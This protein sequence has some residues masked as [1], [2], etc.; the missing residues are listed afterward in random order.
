M[1]SKEQQNFPFKMARDATL[2][3]AILFGLSLLA[4][5]GL[6]FELFSHFTFQYFVAGLFL[7]A[8]FLMTRKIPYAVF[9]LGLALACFTIM[10]APITDPIR[11]ELNKRDQSQLKI[12]QFNVQINHTNQDIVLK[13][14]HTHAMDHDALFFY[15]TSPPLSAALKTLS[16]IYPYQFH[17]PRD[18]AFGMV[19]L[20][21][22]TP[23]A[24]QMTPLG[25]NFI[26]SIDIQPD[27]FKT[28]VRIFSLHALPPG[29]N[30]TPLRDAELLQ[31]AQIIA[32]SRDTPV[33]FI[34]DWNITPYAPVFRDILTIT[35]LSYQVP[36]MRQQPTWPTMLPI[37]M[38]IPIDH[39]LFS[40]D[41]ALVSR[42]IHPD[43][44][45]SD[46]AAI[47]SIFTPHNS[48]PA[49]KP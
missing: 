1:P 19:I 16:S 17:Q 9:T 29:I 22:H 4:R 46:H 2:S 27:G 3:L 34:G 45:W 35:G 49:Q 5:Y 11:F 7:S 43:A 33:I 28:P 13:W 18:H 12:L 48:A 39:T 10:R 26:V 8:F 14:V 37:F 20:S 23:I 47:T 31:S 6:W 41:L 15:E 25:D 21:K 44:P 40:R 24:T 32:E 36:G 42:T 38:R 30:R